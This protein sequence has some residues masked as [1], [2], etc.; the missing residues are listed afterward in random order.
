MGGFLPVPGQ[1]LYGASKAAVKLLTEGLNSELSSTNV[2]VSA[3]F[4]GAVA[5]NIAK[6]SG[7]EDI[8][9]LEE[10]Q[11]ANNMLAPDKA[12]QKILDGIERN[13]YRIVVGSDAAF[14][15]IVYR[16]NPRR[17]A[18]FIYKQMKSLLSE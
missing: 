1:T 12:A 10:G 15:D 16:L 11:G 6:N 18:Q 3:V 14:M 5:T 13:R 7:V 9:G 4:P 2:Q 17:A 8:Q